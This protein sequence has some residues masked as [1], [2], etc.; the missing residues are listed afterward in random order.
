MKANEPNPNFNSNSNSKKHI[1]F[2]KQTE[3]KFNR[4]LDMHLF[5]KVFCN[6]KILILVSQKKNYKIDTFY[7][8]LLC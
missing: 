4:K 3:K 1:F 8:E 5:N 2:L 7:I 6:F